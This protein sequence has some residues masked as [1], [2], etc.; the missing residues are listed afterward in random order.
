MWRDTTQSP[1]GG[2]DS[3]VCAQFLGEV[4]SLNRS[5]PNARKIRVLAGDPPIDWTKVNTTEE[6]V[7]FLS[8]RDEFP[9]ALITQEV[10]R[11]GQKVLVIYGAGHIWRKN[12]LV[13]EPNPPR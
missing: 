5:L 13:K 2:D 6:F 12:Q 10:L 9:A 8:R 11:K 4:R 3:P 7:P 1:V